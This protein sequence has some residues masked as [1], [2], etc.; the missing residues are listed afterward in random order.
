MRSKG[1]ALPSPLLNLEFTHRHNH[2]KTA[3]LPSI[4]DRAVL[5]TMNFGFGVG[6]LIVASS[7]ENRVR[8]NLTES[9]DQFTAAS[10]E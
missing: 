8:K 6:D 9:F 2:R 1:V 3:S 10:D 4:E 7:L 5:T